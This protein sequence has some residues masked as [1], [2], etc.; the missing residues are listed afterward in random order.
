M[1]TTKQ[2]AQKL[3]VTTR[4][5]TA[6]IKAGKLKAQKIGRDWII[7]ESDLAN[8]KIETKYRK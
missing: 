5:V 1:L 3:G 7:K 4:R 6:L 8:V 2:V